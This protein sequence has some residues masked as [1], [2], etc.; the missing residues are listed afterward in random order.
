MNTTINIYSDEGLQAIDACQFLSKEDINSLVEMKNELQ[1][2]FE[3][4]QMWR[5]ETEMRFSVLND[6]KHPTNASKY[7]QAV[8]EQSGFFENLV[9]LSFE[10]RR[11]LVKIKKLEKKINKEVNELKLESLKIDLEEQLF[12]KKNQEIAS[13]D[14]M[15]ELKLWSKI[16]KELDDGSFDVDNVDS[17]QLVSYAQRYLKEYE[18]AIKMKA[19]LNTGEARNLLGQTVSI[20]KIC[21]ENNILDKVVSILPET[22][23]KTQLLGSLGFKKQISG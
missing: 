2:T 19:N 16:K 21:E 7:W 9:M 11:T 6:I 1:D 20:L 15:R 3:K 14:R 13:K 18:A 22:E 5:T 10:Y 12:I 4:K 17:H 23:F 8:K